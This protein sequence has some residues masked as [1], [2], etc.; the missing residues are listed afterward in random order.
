MNGFL[1]SL[2]NSCLSLFLL[3]VYCLLPTAFVTLSVV[4][5]FSQGTWT[6]KTN[7]PGAARIDAVGFSIGSKGYIGPG[8]HTIT[9]GFYKDFWEWDQATNT[10]TQ[11]AVFP[12]R[13][14]NSAVGFSIGNKGYIGTGQGADSLGNPVLLDDF[15]EWDQAT[16]TWSQKANL[17]GG[18]RSNAV[19]FSIGNKG[20][21]GTGGGIINYPSFSTYDDFWEWDQASNTWS[22]KTSI[23]GGARLRAVGFSIGTKGY[24]GTG[25]DETINTPIVLDDFWAWDQATNIWKQ[26][27]NIPF[28]RSCATG[29]S[30]GSY[31]FIGT[32]YYG[33]NN[34]ITGDWWRYDTCNDTWTQAVNFGGGHREGAV[35][36]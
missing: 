1:H 22:Q 34:L 30:I 27:A 10:W 29:F 16:N 18:V 23:P 3:T 11:K 15:W 2:I 35:G 26:K 28:A 24:I 17:P 21:I 33:I 14:R 13:I 25:Q 8:Y 5:G 7:F 32:G 36:F 19:G 31:G 4:E 20:Y 6:Q 12:G 9:G